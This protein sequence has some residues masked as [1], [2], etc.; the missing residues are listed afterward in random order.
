MLARGS[1]GL[2]RC[3]RG[4]CRPPPPP[5]RA[6]LTHTGRSVRL[7]DGAPER[8]R[9]T[10][11]MILQKHRRSRGNHADRMHRSGLFGA[12]PSSPVIR[13]A[14]SRPRPAPSGPVIPSV[15]AADGTGDEISRTVGMRSVVRPSGSSRMTPMRSPQRLPGRAMASPG[16]CPRTFERRAPDRGTGRRKV[17]RNAGPSR[18]GARA[19]PRDERR[20]GS[21]PC[22]HDDL[23]R[24]SRASSRRG[25]RAGR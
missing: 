14:R 23:A 11:R 9:K 2:V 21:P 22:R 10:R 18:C 3:P 16:R 8:R 17:D 5:H 24:R 7:T 20:S 25:C 1:Y 12:R 15:P 19:R 6:P 13:S 4:R